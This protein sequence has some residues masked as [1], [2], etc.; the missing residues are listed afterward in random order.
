MSRELES[1]V[2]CKPTWRAKGVSCG[3]LSNLLWAQKPK[4]RCLR[5]L[6]IISS[7]RAKLLALETS[8]REG[9]SRC[10]R[11]ASL[12]HPQDSRTLDSPDSQPSLDSKIHIFSTIKNGLLQGLLLCPG[13]PGPRRVR[14][15]GR[16]GSQVYSSQQAPGSGLHLLLLQH[17][18]ER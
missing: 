18:L 6:G 1:P 3:F 4:L 11:F 2:G 8:I 10:R 15:A 9:W 5:P 14:R 17:P 13:L 16:G 7:W 12:L